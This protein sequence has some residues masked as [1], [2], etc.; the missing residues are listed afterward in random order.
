MDYDSHFSGTIGRTY[1]SSTPWTPPEAKAPADAPDVIFIVLDD[2]GFSDLGC[3]GSEIETPNMDRLARMGAQYTNFHVTSM[4]SPTRAC[5]LTGRNAHAVGMGAIAEWAG[6]YPSYR[7][8]ISKRAGTLA[9]NLRGHAYSTMAVGKWHLTPM[10]EISA[11]GP[12]TQWPLG[13]GFDHWYGFQGAMT[14]P[15][16]SLGR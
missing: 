6:G 2:V 8:H 4:C 13:R 9:E 10:K 12:F 16:I 1:K 7:G 5:M 15:E 14:D 3:Y 11:A